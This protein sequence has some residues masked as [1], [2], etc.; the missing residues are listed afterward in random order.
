MPSQLTS[1]SG[2]PRFA[3]RAP[4][5]DH[6]PALRRLDAQ[7]KERLAAR[8]AQPLALPDGEMGD[9]AMPAEHMAGAIDNVARLA[10]FGAQPR[11]PVPA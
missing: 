6:D 1:A 5:P 2:D 3:E 4:G 8:D 10:R 9:A 7:H 11:R